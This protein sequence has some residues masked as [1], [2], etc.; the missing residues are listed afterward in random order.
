[1][2][3]ARIVVGYDGSTTSCSALDFAIE[4][5]RPRRARVEVIHA[6]E[7]PPPRIRFAGDDWGP[8]EPELRQSADHVLAEALDHA[9]DMGPDVDICGKL[10]AGNA[11]GSLLEAAEGAHILVVGSRG[12]SGFSGRLLGSTGLQ[13]ATHAACPVVVV[14]PSAAAPTPTP[15]VGR[16]VVGVDGSQLSEAVLAFAFEQA[17]ERGVG[18]TALLAWD[19]SYLNVPGRVGPILADTFEA[20]S[21]HAT[22]VLAETLAGW[23]EQYPDVDITSRTIYGPARSSLIDASAG[24]TLLVV[25]SRGRGGFLRLLLGS[26]SLAVLNSAHCPVAVIHQAES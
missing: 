9:K 13:V 20:E 21:E 16:V 11:A 22:T 8:Q 25:G 5:A 18:L 19:L 7:P 4:S 12:L 15:E 6:W 2:E 3:S 17:A 26:V 23:Q 10:V 1:M 24:A 14:R